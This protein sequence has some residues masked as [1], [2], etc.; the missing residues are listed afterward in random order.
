MTDKPYNIALLVDTTD[1][2]RGGAFILELDRVVGE[3]KKYGEIVLKE[4]YFGPLKLGQSNSEFY[5]KGFEI[6]YADSLEESIANFSSRASEFIYTGE[7]KK[8][9]FLALAIGR[10]NYLQILQKAEENEVPVLIIG[11]E[12]VFKTKTN[13][14]VPIEVIITSLCADYVRL[15]ERS[16]EDIQR[17]IEE[18]KNYESMD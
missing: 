14:P 18:I 2:V 6:L 7:K 12:E 15:D 13:R 3:T 1:L 11:N 10:F 4:A 9:N 17:E 16:I 5:E 8:I